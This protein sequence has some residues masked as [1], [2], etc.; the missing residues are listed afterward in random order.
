MHGGILSLGRAGFEL[1]PERPSAQER[2]V[3]DSSK[4]GYSEERLESAPDRQ[5]FELDVMDADRQ[6]QSEVDLALTWRELTRG[7]SRIVGWFFTD[8]RCGLI[9]AMTNHAPEPTLSGRRLEIIESILRGVGQKTV[10]IDLGVAP[11]TIAL[12]AQ[13]GLASIGATG[14]PSRVHPL[15]MQIVKAA[16]ERSL[17]SGV[18][19]FVSSSLGDVQVISARRPDRHLAMNTPAAELDVVRLL[20]EGRSY[21]QIAA[22]RR[23]SHRTVANQLAAV[24]K[25]LGVSGRNELMVRLLGLEQSERSQLESVLPPTVRELRPVVTRLESRTSGIHSLAVPREPLELLAR[26]GA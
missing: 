2:Q 5:R 7:L 1:D 3:N 23:T 14:R 11:S 19:S 25:R 6:S 21:D 24:F 4:F 26:T 22:C 15:L 13:S 12:H 16:C 18:L 8:D 9:L 17:A 10:A 20:V